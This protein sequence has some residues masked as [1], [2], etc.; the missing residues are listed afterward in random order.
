MPPVWA[1]MESVAVPRGWWWRG[2]LRVA[3]AAIVVGMAAVL[4]GA[5]LFTNA[6]EWFGMRARVG[7]GALGS[8]FAAVGTALPE[9]AIA[10]LATATGRVRRGGASV[11]DAVGLGAIL[12]APLLLATVGLALIGVGALR[13]GRAQVRVP[14]A[15]TRDL[16]FFLVTFGGAAVCGTLLPQ[17][18]AVWRLPLAAA[19]VGG[20]A[21]FL[22]CA[23]GGVGRPVSG[24]ARRASSSAAERG[25]PGARRP[26]PP[27]AL[28]LTRRLRVREVPPWGAIALQLATALALMLTGAELFVATLT[29]LS[30]TLGL[31]GYGLAALIAPV[32]TELPESTNSLVWASQGQDDLAAGNITGALVLQG[33]LVPAVGVL[34]TPWHFTWQEAIGAS[35]GVLGPGIAYLVHRTT[36]SVPSWLLMAFALVYGVN[37]ALLL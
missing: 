23:V 28:L 22:A 26:P 37:L 20:Y 19:L 12:G 17:L 29:G 36:G 31:S 14:Q 30:V 2:G 18:R 8:V 15:F 6:L 10:V 21:V 33:S 34:F 16:P 11:G 3:A 13:R 9:M 5:R 32:A 7:R 1:G 27:A 35:S 24:Q 25:E 4:C